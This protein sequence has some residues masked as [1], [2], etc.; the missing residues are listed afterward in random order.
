M[1]HTKQRILRLQILRHLKMHLFP[2]DGLLPILY[3]PGDETPRHLDKFLEFHQIHLCS[4]GLN[5]GVT[6]DIDI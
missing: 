3:L 6:I 5:R 4:K 2:L 1:M